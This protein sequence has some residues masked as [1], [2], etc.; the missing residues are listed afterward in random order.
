M[1]Q[2]TYLTSVQVADTFGVTV[3]TV[4][5]WLAYGHLPGTKFGTGRTSALMFTVADVQRFG[6]AL[7]TLAAQKTAA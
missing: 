4:S 3:S 6:A 1:A 5:R 7:R 2:I